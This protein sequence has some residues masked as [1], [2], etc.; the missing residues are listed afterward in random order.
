MK[1]TVILCT[2]NRCESLSKALESLA[3]STLPDSVAWE[4]LVV[5]NN[6]SDRTHE[7][8]Q[9]FSELFP[10]RVR[11]LFEPRP[12]KSNA[13]NAGIKNAKGD[14]LAFTD[15]DVIVEPTWLQNLT[16]ALQDAAWAGS[17]GRTLPERDFSPPSW[18]PRKGLYALAPLAVFDR[19]TE[20]FQLTETPY[21]N[22]M[23][24]RKSILEK[25]G[26]FRTDLG[27]RAGSS[28]AQKSED[29]E[30]GIRLLEAGERLRYEPSAVLYHSVPQGRV[31]KS[32][33]LEWWF[34]KSRS[35][36]RGFGIEPNTHWF[37]NGI[38][39]YLF[40]RLAVWTLR[41]L[42]SFEASARFSSKIK[43]WGIAGMILESH[44]LSREPKPRREC[45]ART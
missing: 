28:D 1:I 19:G 34:D 16:A 8:T 37:I 42:L 25:Y 17:A 12:G 29:S 41:W 31:Q 40:R 32:Y 27:P 39:I 9:S 22:N 15:D 3:A 4:V 14:I 7:I 23:A 38:P 11:Y 43:V 35:D 18:I 36:I 26:G 5:D 20:P 24:Y 2:H 21:G 10:G 30:F 6:S 33:F 13:L 45:D 44:H